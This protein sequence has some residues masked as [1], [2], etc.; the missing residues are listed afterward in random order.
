MAIKKVK[1]KVK[2]NPSARLRARKAVKKTKKV[3]VIK[4]KAVRRII[5]KKK[6]VKKILK[7]EKTIKTY[8]RNPVIP[9]LVAI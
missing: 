5:T 3:L 2:K 8:I 4:K 9:Q 6:K 7:I 1:A